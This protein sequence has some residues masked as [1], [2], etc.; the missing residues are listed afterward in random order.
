VAAFR[1][2][3]KPKARKI[4]YDPKVLKK[5]KVSKA[6]KVVKLASKK[7][8]AKKVVSKLGFPGKVVV[9]AW[10]AYDIA[11]EFKERKSKSK[12]KPKAKGKPCKPGQYMN[13]KGV[14][15]SRVTVKNIPKE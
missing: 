12:S 2:E 13:K 6:A 15:I 3:L 5:Y 14:C 9:G 8:L 4:Y 7:S 10:T 11:K 1:K